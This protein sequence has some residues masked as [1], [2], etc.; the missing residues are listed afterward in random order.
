MNFRRLGVSLVSVCALAACSNEDPIVSLN[1]TAG[2]DV[3]VVDKLHVK[4][5]DGSHEFVYDF[6]PP[7]DD[8]MGDAGPSIRNSFFERI[9]LPKS[10]ED[11]DALIHVDALRAGGTAFSPPLSDETTVHI[12]EDGV[13]AAYVKLAFPT[14]PP[15]DG[16]GEA[17]AAG[18]AGSPAA[19]AGAGGVPNGEGGAG[20]ESAGAGG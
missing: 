15:T 18:A 5:T 6:A 3:P 7:L 17:G 20:G 8:A 9:S 2:D 11:R 12:E 4:I 10:F 13:V 14:P 1:V 19:E 16:G